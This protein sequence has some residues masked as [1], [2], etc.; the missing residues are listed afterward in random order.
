MGRPH[1][2]ASSNAANSALYLAG[3]RRERILAAAIDAFARGGFEGASTREIAEAAGVTDPL[4]FY[5]FKSKSELYLASVQD[6]LEKLRE[7]LDEAL[8]GAAGAHAHLRV[9]VEVYL[10]YFLDLEPGLTV[11]LR[12][13]N[14]LPPQAAMAIS[15]THHL[16]VI[17]RL[18]E[19]LVAG[20]QRGDFRPLN[21]PAC[22]LGII[23]IL[24]MFIRAEARNPGRYSREE[25]IAQVLEHYA[26]GLQPATHT[27]MPPCTTM[28][29]NPPG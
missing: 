12:E 15:E 8:A 13:L 9:F 21:V 28:D 2:G 25:A 5:H 19:I 29:G 4:L 11:T 24:Q 22:A 1:R 17:A 6:Q 14:G 27:G 10:R 7:G 20:V 26:V 3:S 18:E 23:G 16:I